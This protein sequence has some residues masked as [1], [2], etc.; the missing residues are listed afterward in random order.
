[1]AAASAG[2]YPDLAGGNIL[3]FYHPRIAGGGCNITVDL[4]KTLEHLVDNIV[5]IVQNSLHDF[6]L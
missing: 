2:Y 5:R 6:F 1:V 4:N 3:P